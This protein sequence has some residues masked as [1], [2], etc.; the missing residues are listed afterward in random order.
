MK[1]KGKPRATQEGLR[2]A[3]A[4]ENEREQQAKE[5]K[6]RAQSHTG[7]LETGRGKEK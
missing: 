6:M 1:G 3:M 7:R 2:L 4:R 5:R